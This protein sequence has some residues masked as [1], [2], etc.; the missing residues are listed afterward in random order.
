MQGP[1]SLAQLRGWVAAGDLLPDMPVE[2]SAQPGGAAPTMTIRR[3]MQAHAAMA[4]QRAARAAP[5]V[6]RIGAKILEVSSIASTR[7]LHCFSQCEC[8]S[9]RG[10][11]S[12]L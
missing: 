10:K 11:L 8:I 12:A 6:R 4:T 2:H 3:A 9:E 7:Q 5:H 1:F